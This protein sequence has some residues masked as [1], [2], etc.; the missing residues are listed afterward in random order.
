MDDRLTL[1]TGA[2][3][4]QGPARNGG[5][6]VVIPDGNS[7]YA[8]TGLSYRVSDRFTLDAALGAVFTEDVDVVASSTDP[9]AIFRG[10]F[11]GRFDDGRAYF[12]GLGLR[13]DL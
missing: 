7:I 12:G 4:D 5:A 11:S 9:E 10:D 1:R 2:A 3:F 6:A 13:I 8:A